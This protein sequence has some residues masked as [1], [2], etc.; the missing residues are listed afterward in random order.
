MPVTL[1]V[2][3][4]VFALR[5]KREA[6]AQRVL[7]YFGYSLTPSKLLCFLDDDDP[8]SL[9]GELGAANRGL[10]GPIHDS[11]P[12]TERPDYVRNCILVDDGVSIYRRVVDDLVYLYGSTCANGVGLAMT[13][14]HELQHAIQH[15][16]VRELWA[17]NSLVNQ[18]EKT[19]INTL[20][21]TWADIPIER[22]ARIVSKRAA[23]HL[24]DEQRVTQYIDEKIR[25]RVSEGDVDDWRFVRSLTL[26]SSVDLM[27]STHM[28]FQRLKGY[29]SELEDA[30]QREKMC[31]PEDF[32]DIDL[33]AFLQVPTNKLD[34]R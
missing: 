26:S 19:V 20:K 34:C 23:S 9:R 15:S 3:S 10:Y 27:G 30:L 6:A 28:L 29:R 2:K 24:F 25:E 12:L 31:N 1:R 18:L 8:S 7:A 16:S 33:D 22:E 32:S 17:V 21:L 13:L 14:A 5:T 11:T 4:E